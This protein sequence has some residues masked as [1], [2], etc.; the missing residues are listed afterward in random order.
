M[1]SAWFSEKV[2][3][4]LI[5]AAVT[6]ALALYTRRNTRADRLSEKETELE[7]SRLAAQQRLVETLQSTLE[8]RDAELERTKHERDT[9]LREVLS[10]QAAANELIQKYNLVRG[11]N[12][13][14]PRFP[15]MPLP[16]AASRDGTHPA[17]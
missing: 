17:H 9:A 2:L 10:L 14:D 7:T 8:R 1:N 5:T 3:P 12:P 4:L 6:L 16:A 15:E 13:G 11:L